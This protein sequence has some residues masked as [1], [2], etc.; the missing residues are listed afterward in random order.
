[1]THRQIDICLMSLLYC[2]AGTRAGIILDIRQSEFEW[3]Q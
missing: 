3:T 2:V 1:V